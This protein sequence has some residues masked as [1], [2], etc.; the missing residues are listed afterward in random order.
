M[1]SMLVHENV[2]ILVWIPLREMV[3]GRFAVC[4]LV[5]VQDVP[6]W[7][8]FLYFLVSAFFLFLK[9]CIH[10]LLSKTTNQMLKNIFEC[11]STN[12]IFRSH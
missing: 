4:L 3:E 11:C 10:N 9:I 2:P 6:K 1:K 7:F 8:D 12:D 5:L